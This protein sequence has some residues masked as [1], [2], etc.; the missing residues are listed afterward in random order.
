M[1]VF[2]FKF[3]FFVVVSFYLSEIIGIIFL[4]FEIS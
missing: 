3:E 2:V 1:M 4:V